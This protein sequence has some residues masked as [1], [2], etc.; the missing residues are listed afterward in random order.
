ML[1]CTMYMLMT[2]VLLAGCGPT[3][4]VDKVGIVTIDG[5]EIEVRRNRAEPDIWE[6]YHV[7][8]E[9]IRGDPRAQSRNIRAIEMVSGCEVDLKSVVDY[10]DFSA[11]VVALKC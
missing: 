9:R 2:T 11:T 8:P 6:A 10:A 5:K 7:V 1:R 3:K 4:M